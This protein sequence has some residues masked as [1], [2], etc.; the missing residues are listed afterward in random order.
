MPTHLKLFTL[1][2][3]IPVTVDKT[4]EWAITLE[5]PG[6]PLIPLLLN[7]MAASEL[8]SQLRLH[9]VL[10]RASLCASHVGKNNFTGLRHLCTQPCMPVRCAGWAN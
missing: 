5:V 3:S 6:P 9:K 1:F 4:C 2:H 10:K 8:R 7:T